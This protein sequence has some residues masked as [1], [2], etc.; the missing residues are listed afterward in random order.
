MKYSFKSFF[1]NG[2]V[3]FAMVRYVSLGLQFIATL[4]IAN[5]LG[6]FYFGIWSF[7]IL[8]KQY[9]AYTNFG[10][11]YS[12]NAILSTNFE[13]DEEYKKNIFQN[14]L[15]ATLIFFVIILAVWVIY[16]FSNSDVFDKYDFKKYSLLLLIFILVE[17]FNQI[18][19]NL[20][21]VYSKIKLIAIFRLLIALSRLIPVL[22]L[23]GEELIYGLLYYQIAFSVLSYGLFVLNSP[24]P[25]RLK[26]NFME[27]K[28]LI[29]RGISLLFYNLSFYFLIISTK[30]FISYFY[31]VEVY[32]EYGF[33]AQLASIAQLGM[34]T[35]SFLFFPKFLN[36]LKEEREKN[37]ITKNLD[38]IKNVYSTL[39]IIITLVTVCFI[40]VI[41]VL[42]SD[43]EQ[44]KEIFIALLLVNV[45][46][47]FSVG[48][49]S[50]LIAWGK[51]MILTIIGVA[52][53]LLNVILLVLLHF[54]T[55]DLFIVLFGTV[56]SGLTYSF[57][58]I[59]MAEKEL[60]AYRSII[61]YKKIVSYIVVLTSMLTI[62]VL[63]L[64]FYWYLLPL[65]LYISFDFNNV[66]LVS[67]KVIGLLMN[68]EAIEL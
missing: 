37:L 34:G 29:K 6:P 51:E 40:P 2:I 66:K 68:K 67:N 43:Y 59:Y 26:F 25:F 65:F 3:P 62:L 7:I 46:L 33:A 17:N 21:R 18:F 52:S 4:L 9:L 13:R 35:I 60:S 56:I 11:N 14:A 16:Y 53:I 64:F 61:S 23:S 19:I 49:N 58:V 50:L 45:V 55:N 41:E 28:I 24:I 57:A 5:K 44:I 39:Y 30:T 48:H 63:D 31:S 22:Y 42:F 20:Y 15:V 12:L 36:R 27:F 8:A 38:M 10:V 54:I 47:S 1:S 32:G